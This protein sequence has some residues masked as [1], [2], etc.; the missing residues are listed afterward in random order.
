M[1]ILPIIK[2]DIL[3]LTKLSEDFDFDKPPQDP[4]ELATNLVDTMLDAK[5]LG[6]AA[7]Q[8][9]IPYRV[10]AMRGN[11]NEKGNPE[12]FCFFNPRI[13]AYGGEIIKLEEG[14]LSF[15]GLIVEIKRPKDVRFRFTLPN[16][17]TDTRM[18]TGITARVI[19]H[20]MDHLD[21]K[22]FYNLANKYKRNL[23]FKQQTKYLKRA[24][25]QAKILKAADLGKSTEILKV[26]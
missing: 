8:C 22:L 9:N 10:F 26:A 18:F 21:G 17:Q 3:T 19:Q 11:V 14:C 5:G 4:I 24:A 16:G 6:L 7:I 15:P 12:M 13:V 25:S 20:E 1:T 23:A 2:Q